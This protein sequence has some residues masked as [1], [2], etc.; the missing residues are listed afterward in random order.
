MIKKLP[1]VY[2]HGSIGRSQDVEQMFK[3]LGIDN[4]LEYK[5]SDPWLIYY[6]NQNNEIAFTEPGTDLY[7]FITN[8]D[9]WTEMKLKSSKIAHKFLITVK[10][11]SNSCDGCHIRGKCTNQQKAKCQLAT[12]LSKLTDYKELT[13]KVLE[14]EEVQD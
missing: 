14:I 13:G 8:S 12:S 9:D 10:E 1:K 5:F 6:V 11:G 4:P 7:Y 2:T 3:K